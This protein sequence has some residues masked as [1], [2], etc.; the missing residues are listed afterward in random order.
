MAEE[1]TTP[2][3]VELMRRSFEAADRRD[4][5]AL[6]SFYAPDAVWDMS[7]MGLG[8]Y[9]NPAAILGFFE[10]WIG[11]Y[12]EYEMA[13]EKALDLG[14]GVAFALAIQKGRPAGSS[15]EVRTR[16]A[17]VVVWEN[18]LIVRVTNYLDIDE[19]RA[20]AERLA[21]ERE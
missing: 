17:A 9:E 12:E 16:Y 18:D 3:L 8:A 20:A 19:A 2:D 11:A 4:F 5:G 6:M 13:L 10:D 1:S 21:R 15:G 14:N 7:P